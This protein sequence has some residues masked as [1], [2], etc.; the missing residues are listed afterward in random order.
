MQDYDVVIN[1]ALP[2][3]FNSSNGF[4]ASSWQVWTYVDSTTDGDVQFTME[5]ATGTQCVSESVQPSITAEWQQITIS[6]PSGC[7]FSA[8]DII[9]LR[10]K[11]TS[12]DPDSNKVRLGEM[13]YQ[14][15]P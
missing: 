5:D 2:N 1:H 3:N 7:S 14:Y 6:D 12:A 10:L 11:L 15:S 9:T 4:D 8:N 13:E